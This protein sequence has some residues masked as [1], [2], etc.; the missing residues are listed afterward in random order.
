M[1]KEAGDTKRENWQTEEA[2]SRQINRKTRLREKKQ[3]EKYKQKRLIDRQA[4][5]RQAKENRLQ[6]RWTI[7][8]RP[9]D[10][11]LPRQ[12]GEVNES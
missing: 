8:K 3:T 4:I 2:K 1:E 9:K 12:S 11:Y 6:H 5:D 7:A 10:R